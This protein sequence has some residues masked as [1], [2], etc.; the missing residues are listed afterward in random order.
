MA[1]HR[2]PAS[3]IGALAEGKLRGD[4]AEAWRLF[5]DV[6]LALERFVRTRLLG[7]GLPKR[8]LSDCGQEVFARVW[9]FRKGYRG[10][11]E[12]EMWRW[13]RQICDNERRRILAR[14]AA[15]AGVPAGMADRDGPGEAAPATTDETFEQ[16][17]LNEQLSVLH[18]CMR[19]LD[20]GRR[21]IIEL[22]YLESALTERAIAELIGCSS[23]SAHKL[24][25][26]GLRLLAACL[27]RHGIRSIDTE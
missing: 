20:A 8:L 2:D 13:I 15:R 24:K 14:E 5:G 3:S 23:S 6:W 17:T 18:E 25:V 10:T 19:G 4:D 7:R 1:E 9:R 26:E 11:T 16:T 22:A 12:G 27:A 21:R